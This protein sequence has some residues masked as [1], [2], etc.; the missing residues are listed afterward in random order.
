MR[1]LVLCLISTFLISACGS[2]QPE[3]ATNHQNNTDNMNNEE[4][5]KAAND[6]FYEALNIMFTGDVEPI[7]NCWS[8]GDDVTYMGPFGGMHS[9]WSKVGAE[10]AQAADLKLGG[11]I[12]CKNLVVRAGDKMGYTMC[13]EEGENM[14]EKGEPVTVNHRATNV[15]RKENGHWKMIHHHTDISTQLQE[16]TGVKE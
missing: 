5:L 11:K 14:N 8:H 3:Q 6:S 12:T 9:G 16:S 15:F 7:N 10:F 13:T 1:V 4:S 2:G